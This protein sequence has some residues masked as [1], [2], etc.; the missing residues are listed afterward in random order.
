MGATI[1]KRSLLKEGIGVAKSKKHDH[2]VDATEM[3][4]EKRPLQ[5]TSNKN[6][7]EQE[8]LAKLQDFT[9]RAKAHAT[10]E[11]ALANIRMAQIL[12]DQ[13]AL[14][15]FMMLKEDLLSPQAKEYLQLRQDKEMTRI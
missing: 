8:W 13:I 12:Q 2:D 3:P 6:M 14:S 10:I 1:L 5:P 11:M 7:K 4:M 15:L 9:Q